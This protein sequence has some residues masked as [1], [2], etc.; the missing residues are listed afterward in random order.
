MANDGL[1][2]SVEGTVTVTITN[3]NDYPVAYHT[4]R[5]TTN[6]DVAIIGMLG[7][8][9]IDADVLEFRLATIPDQG[10]VLITNTQTGAFSY[11][12]HKDKNGTD[13]FYFVVHDGEYESN[14]AKVNIDI[15][16]VN[17]APTAD[18][19]GPLSVRADEV[20]RGNLVAADIDRDAL[21]YKVES[22]PSKGAV[23][24]DAGTGSFTFTPSGVVIGSDSFSFTVDDGLVKSNVATVS[25]NITG[26]N[27]LSIWDLR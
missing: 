18:N 12:P 6:E 25:I 3:V 7:G 26:A 23:S 17:D 8:L 22:T 2:N 1:Q 24:I 15:A 19:Q 13:A 9:D 4:G 21:V 16:P 20:L 5:L 10:N 14:V 11:T 27:N